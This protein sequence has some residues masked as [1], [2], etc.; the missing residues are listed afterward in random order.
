MAIGWLMTLEVNWML[1]CLRS[2]LEKKNCYTSNDTWQEIRSRMPKVEW[3]GL[4]LFSS[5]IPKQAFII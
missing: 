1:N 5:P 3:W 2:C 4:D